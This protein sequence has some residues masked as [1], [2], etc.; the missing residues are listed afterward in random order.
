MARLG[1]GEVLS[2][3]CGTGR[4]RP[5]CVEPGRSP[6]AALAAGAGVDQEQD[7]PESVFSL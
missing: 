2:S 4:I 3:G 1:G 7:W 6:A 5:R